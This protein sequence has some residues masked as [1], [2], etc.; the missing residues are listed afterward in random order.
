MN[1]LFLWFW[2]R[3]PGGFGIGLS[4]TLMQSLERTVGGGEKPYLPASP[5]SGCPKSAVWDEKS[6]TMRKAREGCL[7]ETDTLEPDNMASA[8]PVDT[9]ISV[10]RTH[11]P[12]CHMDNNSTPI[13]ELHPNWNKIFSPKWHIAEGF[14]ILNANDVTTSEMP[15]SFA[16]SKQRCTPVIS[17]K[18]KKWFLKKSSEL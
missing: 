9:H 7:G 3:L 8:P 17:V 14:H 16:K 2:E 5:L 4:E 13:Q 12:Y 11:L 18:Y 6:D 15:V 1:F 10:T